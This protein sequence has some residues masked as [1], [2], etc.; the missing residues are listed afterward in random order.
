MVGKWRRDFEVL[1]DTVH[2]HA[3]V[4]LD[5]AAT[6]QMPRQVRDRI[7]GYYAH[8]HANVHRGVHYLSERATGALERARSHVS[9]FI[10]AAHPE[11]VVFTDGATDSLN[12]VA[13]GLSDIIEP[14]TAVV[15]SDLEHHSNFVPWQRLCAERGAE[16]LIWRSHDG[17]L[18]LSELEAL[19][20]G[21][22]V[23][24]VAVTQV[25]NVTGTVVPV[26][27]VAALAHRFGSIA[28][29][30]GAQGILHEGMDASA[31]GIDLYAFSAHKMLGPTGTGVLYGR[32]DLLESLAPSRFGGG[33]VG[34]VGDSE[35]TFGALPYRLEAGTPNIS[36]I[37]GLDAAISYLEENGLDEMRAHERELTAYAVERLEALDGVAVLGHPE[38]RSSIVSFELAGASA[39]DVAFM[40]DKLGVAVRSGHHCAQPALR[41]LGVDSTVRASVAPY[42]EKDDIDALCDGLARIRKMLGS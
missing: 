3:L 41:S 35:T 42:N 29:A 13:R 9:A 17:R 14:G 31:S 20:A 10:G 6:T 30:D 39:F 7:A 19:L 24:V 12:M 25:S 38:L 34:T 1:D 5:N 21:H 36:G 33:M 23:K 8:E 16:F 2:G 26:T 22:T 40:L 11:E 15:V 4:Y 32:R 27:D 37:I 18:S 28:V